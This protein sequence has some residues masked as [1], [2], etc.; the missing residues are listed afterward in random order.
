MIPM[1]DTVPPG[2]NGC[3]KIGLEVKN[4]LIPSSALNSMR[5]RFVSLNIDAKIRTK[6]NKKFFLR[7]SILVGYLMYNTIILKRSEKNR[8]SFYH[9]FRRNSPTLHA[10]FS[11]SVVNM[12]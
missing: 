2:G 8:T 5:S 3:P 7:R 9:N 4:K 1:L 6:I 11:P 12:G 10:F